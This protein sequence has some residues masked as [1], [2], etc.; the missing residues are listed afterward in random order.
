M[1]PH[2]SA[3]LLSVHGLHWPRGG[4][5]LK[6]VAPAGSSAHASEYL[7]VDGS[8]DGSTLSAGRAAP[9]QGAACLG[10]DCTPAVKIRMQV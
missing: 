7:C 8:A 6:P 10:I 5:S 1:Q 2:Q 4:I 3:Q 9:G